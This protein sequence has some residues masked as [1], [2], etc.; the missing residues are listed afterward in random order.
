[1]TPTDLDPSLHL[2]VTVAA[3]AARAPRRSHVTATPTP[4]PGWYAYRVVA[5]ADLPSWTV[6]VA[7]TIERL[8]APANMDPRTSFVDGRTDGES[9]GTARALLLLRAPGRARWLAGLAEAIAEVETV[10]GVR[11]ATVGVGSFMSVRGRGG[12]QLRMGPVLP[13]LVP[14]APLVTQAHL[15]AAGSRGLPAPLRRR[16]PAGGGVEPSWWSGAGSV[17][18]CDGPDG[19]SAQTVVSL[20]GL[21]NVAAIAPPPGGALVLRAW[22]A[23]RAWG[24]ACGLVLGAPSALGLG[25]EAGRVAAR[26]RT[27]GWNAFVLGGSTALQLVRAGDP[28]LPVPLAAARAATGEQVAAILRACL[29]A[30]G[31]DP[32]PAGPSLHR[33]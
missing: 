11:P 16:R 8:A 1:M 13:G 32:Q 20:G 21:G 23:S 28:R 31:L 15:G 29:G 27:E 22:R 10:A 17:V 6:E 9:G 7:L 5:A 24:L 2:G 18:T 33:R 14:A 26:A 30:V 25:R 19:M 12:P 3:H 4:R